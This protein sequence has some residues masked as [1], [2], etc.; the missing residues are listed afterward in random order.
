MP[1]LDQALE[2]VHFDAAVEGPSDSPKEKKKKS[3]EI[4]ETKVF[5]SGFFFNSTPAGDSLVPAVPPF[6]VQVVAVVPEPVAGEGHHQPG[7][8][9]AV[10]LLQL[11]KVLLCELININFILTL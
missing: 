11:N 7:P 9:R 10:H 4:C 2:A 8:W 6:S 5:K 3:S 1:L